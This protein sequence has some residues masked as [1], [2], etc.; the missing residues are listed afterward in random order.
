MHVP[1]MYRAAIMSVMPRYLPPH[2]PLSTTPC[3][4]IYHPTPAPGVFFP[5]LPTLLL[6]C[7]AGSPLPFSFSF[8]FFVS[9]AISFSFGGRTPRHSGE[10]AAGGIE[11]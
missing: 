8:S 11:N 3:S 5:T 9:F 10:H 6:H 4:A 1:S 7:G 2:A